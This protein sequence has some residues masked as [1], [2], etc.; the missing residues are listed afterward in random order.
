M[1]DHISAFIL[2]LYF[3]VAPSFWNNGHF[4]V[5]TQAVSCKYIGAVLWIPCR[6]KGVAA[7]PSTGPSTLNPLHIFRGTL[8]KINRRYQALRQEHLSERRSIHQNLFGGD[9]ITGNM[10]MHLVSPLRTPRLKVTCK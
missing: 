10:E 1:I 6:N 3:T 8:V 4:S 5:R 2:P 9:K 7:G